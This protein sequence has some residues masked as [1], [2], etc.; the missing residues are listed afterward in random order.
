MVVSSL[1]SS[2]IVSSLSSSVVVSSLVSPSDSD[3]IE[4]SELLSHSSVDGRKWD[5][6]YAMQRNGDI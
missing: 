6:A 4:V 5:A 1:S 3:L 2:V